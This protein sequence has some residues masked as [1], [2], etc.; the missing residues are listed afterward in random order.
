MKNHFKPPISARPRLPPHPLS[1]SCCVGT[2]CFGEK[3]HLK[4]TLSLPSPKP[5]K[6]L[7]AHPSHSAILL[8]SRNTN[9]SFWG[10]HL[11]GKLRRAWALRCGVERSGLEI[12]SWGHGE[13]GGELGKEVFGF[14]EGEPSLRAA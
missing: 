6:P 8:W 10:I 13:T 3:G 5:T 9:P 2:I 4:G 14:L 1:S 11:G 12:E 7:P